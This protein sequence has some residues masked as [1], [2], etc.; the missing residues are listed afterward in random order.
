M[1]PPRHSKI[2]L[3]GPRG[4]G[5]STVGRGVA[6]R[7]KLAFIDLDERVLGRLG[8]VSVRDAWERLGE[9]AWRQAEEMALRE[10]LTREGALVVA[11]G[12]GTPMISGARQ[13][14]GEA[15]A[16]G[17]VFVIYLAAAPGEL[18]R[19]RGAAGADDRPPLRGLDLEAEV[20]ETLAER[21]P[22]YRALADLV[23]E[24]TQDSPDL[25]AH[26]LVEALP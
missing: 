14:I 3:I 13:A 21:E 18:I 19:R 9:A 6:R 24:T 25:T 20:H 7:L 10:V 1:T 4:C 23:I 8:A 17:G 12:G 2:L 11:L 5:K 22:T 26:R 16:A 15:R